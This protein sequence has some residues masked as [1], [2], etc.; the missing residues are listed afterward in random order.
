[1]MKKILAVMFLTSVVA[2]AP[3]TAWADHHHH[4]HHHHDDHHG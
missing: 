1:M 2:F 4:H 3:A